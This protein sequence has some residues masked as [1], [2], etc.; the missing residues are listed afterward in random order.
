MIAC[1]YF[2]YLT[3]VAYKQRSAQEKTGRLAASKLVKN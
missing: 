3:Q 2:P 1:F